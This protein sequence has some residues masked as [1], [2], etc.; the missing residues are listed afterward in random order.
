MMKKDKPDHNVA[1]HDDPERPPDGAAGQRP[2]DPLAQAQAE[3]TEYKDK[4]LRAQAE[5]ANVSRRLTDERA[6]ALR[7]A[8]AAFARELLTVADNF[9]RLIASAA[10]RPAE[11]P[12]VEGA[13][14]IFESLLKVLRNHG[15]EPI[16]TVGK[17]FDPRLHE[18]LL[19][20]P[21]DSVP[22]GHV[23]AEMTKG[24]RM[25]DRVLRAA[26]VAVARK[27]DDAHNDPKGPA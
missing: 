15:V 22:A 27:P 3:A 13:K 18:A 19:H 20:Q 17:A 16:E 6:Q 4:Y 7:N 12:V 8:N 26:A 1:M 2:N 5:I 24:Y 10:D 23:V 21:S 25:N 11:D 9:E 14:L